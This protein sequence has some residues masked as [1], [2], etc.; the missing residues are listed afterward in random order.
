MRCYSRG[1]VGAGRAAPRVFTAEP[2]ELQRRERCPPAARRPLP[3][4][5]CPPAAR[6]HNVKRRHVYVSAGTAGAGPA[7]GQGLPGH[8]APRARPGTPRLR[9]PLPVPAPQCQ[10]CGPAGHEP[11]VP[12]PVACRAPRGWGSGGRLHKA[13]ALP[14]GEVFA[15]RPR[16]GE[17]SWWPELGERCRGIIL[18]V[19]DGAVLLGL[20][21]EQG[22]GSRV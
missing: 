20:C 14:L 17:P 4:A 8:A 9:V 7:G 11:R 2:A 5:H 19:G 15:A 3:A 12:V 10:R 22:E 1:A 13:E 21:R 18:F 16:R 6:S